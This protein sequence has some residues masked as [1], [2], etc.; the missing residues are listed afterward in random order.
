QKGYLWIA[1][2]LGLSRYDGLNFRTYSHPGQINLRTADIVEDG[3]GRIWFHNFSGQVF[4]IENGIVHL[5]ASYDYQHENQS[6]RMA[7]CGNSLFVTS[8]KGLFVCNTD[9]LTAKFYSFRRTIATAVVSLAVSENK[10]VVFNNLDWYIFDGKRLHLVTKQPSLSLPAN[11]LVSLQ[12]AT[13]HDT[14]FLTANP[15]GE[16]YKLKVEND[17]VVPISRHAYH[18]FISAVTVDDGVWVH[19]RNRSIHLRTGKTIYNTDLTDVVKDKEGNV[20][21]G[22]R[23]EGLLVEYR[24]SFWQRINFQ[25]GKNDYIRSLNANAG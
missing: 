15:S 9:D 1:H 21:Y 10:A 4:Y 6:P 18:D 3:H 23:R 14:L 12:P 24:P 5:L 22:S 8:Y 2:S 25:I 20:W 16:F 17:K 11:D 13:F 7:I 19:T